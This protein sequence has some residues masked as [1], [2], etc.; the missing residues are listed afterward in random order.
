M[1]RRRNYMDW[2]TMNHD[3]F[4][5]KIAKNICEHN[6]VIDLDLQGNENE[7]VIKGRVNVWGSEYYPE[8]RV[9]EKEMDYHCNCNWNKSSV[10]PHAIALI[11]QINQ[12]Q[13]KEI[14]YT[15]HNDKIE[16]IANAKQAYVMKK[17]IEQLK[18]ATQVSKKLIE[19]HKT[20]YQNEIQVAIPQK[21]VHL[22]MSIASGGL[23]PTIEYKVGNERMYVVQNIEEFIQ[24]INQSEYHSYGKQLGFVHK[25]T[26]FDEFSQ[27][28]IQWMKTASYL[29]HSYYY[30]DSNRYLHLNED[31][32]D[33]FYALYESQQNS[34]F[35]CKKRDKKL[36]LKFEQYDDFMICS[37]VSN[38]KKYIFAKKNLYEFVNKKGFYTINCIELDNEGKVLTL[39]KQ[40]IE[41]DIVISKDELFD[42]YKYILRDIEDYFSFQGLPEFTTLH[43]E[44]ILLYG[45]VNEKDEVTFRLEY[46]DES[47]QRLPG[48]DHSAI[49]D[50]KSE[51]VEEYLK[52]SSNR[53]ERNI[54]Y[55]DLNQTE[56]YQFLE[57]GL[58]Y[59]HQYCEIYISDAL[60][61][62]H[63]NQKYSITVG[64][65]FDGNL[66]SL[67]I[68]SADIPKS[69]LGDVLAQYRRKRK[70]YRLK[71]G[72]V[73]SLNSEALEELDS[74]VEQYQID[75][76]KLSEKEINLDAY[77]M[78]SIQEDSQNFQ[79]L[80][81]ERKKT[82]EKAIDSFSK[83]KM[84][85]IEIPKNFKDILRDYQKD[86]VR[87]MKLLKEYHFSGILADD[88]GL[89]KT[90][91]V[92]ALIEDST[93]KKPSLVVCPSSLVYNW[94]DEVLKFTHHLDVECIAGNREQ[95]KEL[96]ATTKAKLLITSYDY[97]RRD[98][99]LYENKKFDYVI[100]DE[101]QYIKNQKTKNA[102]SVKK[103]NADHRLALTG[104]PIENTLAELWSIFDFLMPGYLYNYHYFQ[105]H[106]EADIIRND[107]DKKLALKKLVTPF[108]LRRNKKDVLKELP[109][110]VEKTQ[111]IPFS[112]EE[113]KLY[114]AHMAQ[115]NEQLAEMLNMEQVDKIAIL[116]MLTRLRQLC[117]EPRLVYENIYK[118]SSKLNACIEIIQNLKENHQKVLLFSSFT[119]MLDLIEEELQQS[120][121]SYYKLTGKTSKEERRELVHQFQNDDTTVFLI[122][123]K[124]G[125]TGLNL[126]AA[127]AVIHYDPWWNVSAQNQAT[128]RAYRIG[129]EKNVQVF[130]LVMKDSIEE[131]ILLLQERKKELADTFVENNEG[132]LANMSKEDIMELFK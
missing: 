71:N 34:N 15:Y 28:Q 95:R 42:F 75:P 131:K 30:Y 132:S 11:Y 40:L 96:V 86:G 54:A 72:Q 49:L 22:E 64:I 20:L 25:E 89:G 84:D 17:R 46:I 112:E 24:R 99:E 74:M 82:F 55:F 77:R 26:M 105:S 1:T 120:N 52:L 29:N 39:I 92:I 2:H 91:Q 87:W 90:L 50:Q 35:I 13:V 104:T 118:P 53:I 23:N 114:F 106:Y 124:A 116:A 45:D 102:Q 63:S 101:A 100:L 81:F 19:K 121:I 125:G 117:C 27:Q 21:K 10:C 93:S 73:I 110:K 44:K 85:T 107:V 108:I 69:E 111:I 59:L 76:N 70:F 88:M 14:P 98:E 127:Q 57:D 58:T 4:A 128:D 36:E 60:K 56:T 78:F 126:T 7:Y 48:F 119:S 94:K 113:S 5:Q 9:D 3:A 97:M 129:Q 109:D 43:I 61:R 32:L 8:I 83:I 123:L 51:I 33:Q 115:V 80:S 6:Q 18:R 68:E 62:I 12:N 41:Q 31:N 66:L 38:I 65:R 122:S 37:L 67:N 79:N 130:K 47:Q 103:L 16:K